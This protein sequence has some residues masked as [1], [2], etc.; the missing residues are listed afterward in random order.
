[1][2]MNSFKIQYNNFDDVWTD[3][4]IR[5]HEHGDDRYF[6]STESAKSF[7]FFKWTSTT[8]KELTYHEFKSD[9]VA[10][11]NRIIETRNCSVRIVLTRVACDGYDEYGGLFQKLYEK[12]IWQDGQ[13]FS[14]T[15]STYG[16]L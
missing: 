12:T 7:W 16:K 8:T 11:C 5:Y 9:I 10:A 15:P 6:K 2:S 4:P 14:W 3:H 13:W 1:M